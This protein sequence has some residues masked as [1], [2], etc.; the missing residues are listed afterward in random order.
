MIRISLIPAVALF[1]ASVALAQKPMPIPSPSPNLSGQWQG[2]LHSEM[3]SKFNV[4][5]G[6]T[7]F[8]EKW[9]YDL[10]LLV[11]H[12][13]NV[14][15]KA[16]GHLVSPPKCSFALSA[17]TPQAK[18]KSGDVSGKFDGRQFEIQIKIT[19]VDGV[20]HGVDIL[21]SGQAP[22]ILVVPLTGTWVAVG[23][24]VY[25]TGTAATVVGSGTQSVT[26]KRNCGGKAAPTRDPPKGN[27]C[28][29]LSKA[30]K[31]FKYFDKLNVPINAPF[32]NLTKSDLKKLDEFGALMSEIR[33]DFCDNLKVAKNSRMSGGVLDVIDNID[34]LSGE[35]KAARDNNSRSDAVLYIEEDLDILENTCKS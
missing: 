13:G 23:P 3:T 6:G 26:L 22:K 5:S 11:G 30:I 15:G 8:G 20:T 19:R 33:D 1:C 18:N 17:A 32:A 9:D 10:G 35:I 16:V 2:T 31:D 12:D 7:C 24:A 34:E 25:T 28:T 27:R 21:N 4:G 14:Q 29:N